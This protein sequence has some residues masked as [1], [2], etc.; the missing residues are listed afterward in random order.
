MKNPITLLLLCVLLWSA[1]PVIF[2]GNSDPNEKLASKKLTSSDDDLFGNF[3][4]KAVTVNCNSTLSNQTTVGAGNAVV[5]SD[6]NNCSNIFNNNFPFTGPDKVYRIQLEERSHLKVILTILDAGKDLDLIIFNACTGAGSGLSACVQQVS[7]NT[8]QAGLTEAVEVFLEAGTYYIVVDG[9]NTNSTFQGRFNISFQCSCTCIEDDFDVVNGNLILCENFESYNNGG[10]DTQSLRWSKWTSGSGDGEV[11]ENPS[12]AGKALFI[13]SNANPRPDVLYNLDNK[14]SGRYRISFEMFVDRDQTGYYDLLHQGPNTSGNNANFAYRVFFQKNGIGRLRL[15][16]Q[17][18]NQY[19][20]EFP[21]TINAWNNIMQIIDIDANVAELWVNN[22]LV[23]SWAFNIGQST[24]NRMA[25][26]SFFANAND[27]SFYIDNICVWQKNP[28]CFANTIITPVCLKNGRQYDNIGILSCDLYTNAELGFCPGED[29]T[30]IC[31]FGGTF[32]YRTDGIDFSGTLDTNEFIPALIRQEACVQETYDGFVPNKLFADIYVFY[33]NDPGTDIAI[34]LNNADPDDDDNTLRAAIFRCFCEEIQGVTTCRQVCLNAGSNPDVNNA[35]EGFYYIAIFSEE[36]E[37]YEFNIIPNGTCVTN[38]KLIACNATENGT[39]L[40]E[41]NN[42]STFGEDFTSTPYQTCYSGPRTYNGEDVEYKLILD[43]PSIISIRMNSTAPMGLFLYDF[44]CGEN[45]IAYA[46]NSDNGG[47]AF[48]NNLSLDAGVYYIIIDKANDNGSNNFSLTLE[49][50]EDET[51]PIF[52]NLGAGTCPK[53]QASKHEVTLRGLTNTRLNGAAIAPGNRVFFFYLPD[54]QNPSSSTLVQESYQTWNGQEIKFNFYEDFDGDN[55]KCGYEQGE[56]FI[57]KVVDPNDRTYEVTA[58]YQNQNPGGT[59]TPNASSLIQ[60]LTQIGQPTTLRVAPSIKDAASGAGTYSFVIASNLDW[61]IQKKPESTW[62]QINPSSGTGAAQV[63]IQLTQ[64]GS[65]NPRADTL[66]VLGENNEQRR[67][68]IRQAGC[69][70]ASVVASDDQTI[71]QGSSANLTASASPANNYLWSTGATIK[72]ITVSPNTTTFY[73]VATTNSGC[74][75]MDTVKVTVVPVP[76]VDLGE[77]KTVCQGTSIDLTAQANG[78]AGSYTF[79]WD[80]N[81]GAGQNKTVSPNSNTI[82]S[83]TITDAN[84]CSA[85]DQITVSVNALPI[86]NAGTDQAVCQGQSANLFAQANGGGGPYTF[87][88]D[89]NLGSGQNKTVTPSSNTIYS[90]TVTDANQCSATDQIT[91]SVNALPTVNAGADQAVCQ[92]QSANLF[93]QANG[94]AGSYTFTWDNNLGSGQNKTVSPNSNTSYSV[95]VTDANQCSAS[96]QITVSVN[97][98]P[99]ANAGADQAVCQGQ[100]ANLFAQANSGAGSYTFAWDNNLGAGQNKT[101]TPNS[102]TTYTVTV[103]DANQCSASDQITINVKP[104]PSINFGEDQRICKGDSAIIKIKINGGAGFFGYNWGNNL[105]T[106]GDNRTIRPEETTAYSLTVSD[107]N[108]CTAADTITVFVNPAL[109]VDSIIIMPTADAN[110]NGSIRVIIGSGTPPYQ[111]KWLQNNQIISTLE[112][113]QGLN[114]GN[115]TLEITDANGCT[116]R[117]GGLVVGMTTAVNDPVLQEQ[118]KIF[119]NPTSGK[120]YVQFDF[121]ENKEVIIQIHDMLG[122]LLLQTKPKMISKQAQELNLSQYP[123]GL[124]LL[125][126]KINQHIITQKIT[127]SR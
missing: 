115:Y 92:G 16:N 105:G 47:A 37:S 108:A 72:D 51:F 42:Y 110:N 125:K 49:C 73:T 61:A 46:E 33:N 123:S 64:N 83:V 53:D 45:C 11:G 76:I 126:I 4:A 86:A 116:F 121:D 27:N 55:V 71:C 59:F 106:G 118:I 104:T 12:S 24:S 29:N 120:L 67:I 10:I 28:A 34:S 94:G 39:V 81:L 52:F 119:P 102:N 13:S 7:A 62:I 56:D 84:Q 38:T 74:T 82:Y 17:S 70:L 20:K 48:I 68:I 111:F 14:S 41:F 88:W 97:A 98:L 89:N 91:I 36:K 32:I 113:I 112:N 3:C 127:L 1:T 79:A 40:N 109:T 54:L 25:F 78:G 19:I 8:S 63:S 35:A 99:I 23:H 15:G 75:D 44:L 9:E 117:S 85:S 60:N 31:D 65:T 80:N 43:K 66:F 103:T 6:Y 87:N 100:S 50:Q 122:K 96:D 95:T 93:A 5:N 58:A 77:N 30:T 22:E 57:I 21:Y 124:Y 18:D 69:T 101:V 107:S 114:P 90:V 26:L 2:A